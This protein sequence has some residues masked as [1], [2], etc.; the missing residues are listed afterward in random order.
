MNGLTRESLQS[1]ED[2]ELIVVL[3]GVD[4]GVS[5]NIQVKYLP[6]YPINIHLYINC[7]VPFELVLS[8]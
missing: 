6:I 1:D 8:I 2:F 3:D 5:M 4:E 7:R